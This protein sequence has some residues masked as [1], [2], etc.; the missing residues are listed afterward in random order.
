MATGYPDDSSLTLL[1]RARV[2]DSEALETLIARYRPR[3][4]RWASGRLPSWARDLC[5]TDDI[6]QE[7]LLATVRSLDTFEPRHE[8]AL[9]VYLRQAVTSR[10]LNEG[11]RARRRPAPDRLDDL[12]DRF[13]AAQ[14]HANGMVG[15][16]RIAYERCLEGLSAQDREAIIGRLEFGYSYAE[17]AAAWGKRSPEAARKAVE[18]AIRRL[19]SLMSV[20]SSSDVE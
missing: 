12:D 6:V 16:P 2:G 4:R 3:M 1:A 11:R 5:E 20:T 7:A 10:L 19:A 15:D 18:R 8:A 9:T 13:L 14:P 17:L